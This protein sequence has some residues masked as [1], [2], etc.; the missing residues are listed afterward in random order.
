MAQQ[1]QPRLAV[2]VFAPPDW[3]GGGATPSCT[4]RATTGTLLGGVVVGGGGLSIPAAFL[5]SWPSGFFGSFSNL[6]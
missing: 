2:K 3:R 4:G 1:S 6:L 5:V